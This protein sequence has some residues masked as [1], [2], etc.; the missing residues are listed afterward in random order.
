[1]RSASAGE[2]YRFQR[3]ALNLILDDM[4]FRAAD[5]RPGDAVPAFD[6]PTIEGD[7]I[8][9]ADLAAN[10]PMLVVFGSITCPVTDSAMPGLRELHARF[11]QR[12]RFVMVS[13]REAH[14]GE[15]I[16][17][18]QTDS[19]K[20]AH[21][22]AMRALHRIPF[23][24]AV[25]DLDGTLHRAFGPKPNSV[26]LLGADGTILFRA[27]WAN[28]IKAISEA[29]DAALEGRTPPRRETGGT[30]LAMV[31]MLPF[32]APVLDRAGRR[33]WRDMWRV[34]PPLAALAALLRLY[35][36]VSFTNRTSP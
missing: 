12:I 18:A 7:R 32:V 2:S 13:V 3:L 21:A 20:R 19:H 11:G 36:S 8:R 31:R 24:V 5:P 29:L 26:Y 14:P 30:I 35:Q 9:S 34:A 27:H 28:D 1:M 33:A 15:R 16:V 22:V 10:G 17:Q 23:A 25:D 4:T 6:L